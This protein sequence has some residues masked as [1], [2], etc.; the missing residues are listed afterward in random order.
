MTHLVCITSKE[1]YISMIDY[2]LLLRASVRM[3]DT[4]SPPICFRIKRKQ[5]INVWIIEC[6][7]KTLLPDDQQKLEPSLVG[8]II[9]A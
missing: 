1:Y 9:G 6:L 7:F 3:F 8:R 2:Y 4:I 5:M